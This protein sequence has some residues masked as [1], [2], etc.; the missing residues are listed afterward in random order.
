[1]IE[2]KLNP[3]QRLMRCW[4]ELH[5]YNAI[6]VAEL[7]GAADAEALSR[8]ARSF[9]ESRG[10][11]RIEVTG[12]RYTLSA[13]EADVPVE[14][15]TG[16]LDETATRE[17]NRP[18]ADGPAFPLRLFVLP[19][20]GGGHHV[21][22]VVDHF[23]L[24]G[25]SLGNVAAQVLRRAHGEPD[26][27]GGFTPDAP[28]YR[29]AFGL[30]PALRAPRAI[31]RLLELRTAWSP[32][33]ADARD[34]AVSVESVDLPGDVLERL[35]ARSAAQGTTIG[36]LLIE[37]LA[38]ALDAPTRDART[39]RRQDLSIGVI[40]NLAPHS[41]VPAEDRLGV[42]LGHDTALLRDR[43]LTLPRRGALA[44][45]PETWLGGALWPFVVARERPRFHARQLVV[46][47][48]LSNLVLAD[49]ALGPLAGR[50]RGWR[51]FSPTGP[52]TPL[53]LRV[54]T[55]LGRLSASLTWRRQGYRVDQ[56]EAIRQRFEARLPSPE[57]GHARD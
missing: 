53:V 24:D 41:V 54:T 11:S 40:V 38:A 50:V 32:P 45:L 47:A 16:S 34:L 26:P 3:M 2:L 10:M 55:M 52:I 46:S 31:G 20:G 12:R 29:R 22:F 23:A 35:R 36:T 25:R 37:A 28:S 57:R 4:R 51:S 18:F 7:E 1:M 14:I 8:A 33:L 21:G 15:V 43:H 19:T 17:M 30:A 39:G 5:P 9:L 27:P 48:G 13:G 42:F 44:S 49:A 56:R 6:E